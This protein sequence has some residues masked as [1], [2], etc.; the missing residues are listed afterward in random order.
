MAGPKRERKPTP[1][2]EKFAR[3]AVELGN[4]AE[5]YRQAYDVKRMTNVAVANEALRLTKNPVIA[6]IMDKIRREMAEAHDIT[7][8]YLTNKL[9]AAEQQA[10]QLEQPGAR[11]QAIMGMAKLHGMIIDQR[12]DVTP[13]SERDIDAEL[14]QLVAAEK[15]E[16]AAEPAEGAPAHPGDEQARPTVS[17]H[18]S[19]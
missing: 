3:L 10:Q 11:T 1:K 2:Q 19:A 16:E 18:G 7:L 5:A 9:K 8:E 15:E 13:R 17:G 14:H 6:Q 12:R 4:N